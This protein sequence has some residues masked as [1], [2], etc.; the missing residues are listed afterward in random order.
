MSER[1]VKAELVGRRYDCDECGA[2]MEAEGFA[3]STGYA[4]D[5]GHR[6]ANGHQKYLKRSY[7]GYDVVLGEETIEDA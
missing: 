6:C 1:K 4:T 7:P 2:E 3:V 5:Y